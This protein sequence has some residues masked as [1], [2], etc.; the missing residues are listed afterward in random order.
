MLQVGLLPCPCNAAFDGEVEDYT[1]V[2]ATG[3]SCATPG[4]LVSGSIT[5]ST[6]LLSWTSTGA[7]T[8]NLNWKLASSSTW[9]T[10]SGLTSTSYSLTG[11]SA[12]KSYNFQV[13]GVCSG[14]PGSFSAA[15]SFTTTGCAVT[16]CTSS[17]TTNTYEWINKIVM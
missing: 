17:G 5:N 13:Q 3:T 15:S 2:V 8:Y 12:C 6:A 16:Y 1:V 9:T 10:V 11:L 4:G 7:A 14:T